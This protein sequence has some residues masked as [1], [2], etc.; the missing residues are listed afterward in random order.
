MRIFIAG[1]TGAI[2]KRLVPLLADRGH[3]VVGMTRS[4]AKADLVRRLGA[5]PAVPT[6]STP[7]P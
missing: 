7:T 5:R 1:A 2:G 4:E 3:E 6:G